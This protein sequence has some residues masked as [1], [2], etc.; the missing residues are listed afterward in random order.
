MRNIAPT[1]DQIEVLNKLIKWYKNETRNYIT[2]G[3]YAGTGKTTVV[4]LFR[5][6]LG[7]HEKKLKVAFCSYTGK[8]ALVLKNRLASLQARF[9]KDTVGTIHSLIY[10]PLVASN[11]EI[12]G[13]ELKDDIKYDLLVVDEASMLDSK[14]W[15]D[16]LSFGIRI[17]AVG[18]HGQLPPING[19]FNLMQDPELKLETIHRQASGDPIIGLSV[20]AR[21]K[22][23]IPAK[24]FGTKTK[25]LDSSLP[26]SHEIIMSLLQNWSEDTIVLCGYNS[27]RVKINNFVR[28]ALGIESPEPT[29]GDRVICLRNNHQKNIFNGMIG[30][31]TYIAEENETMYYAEIIFNE[32]PEQYSGH[33]LKSQF[34]NE[35]SINYTKNRKATLKCD[36]FDFGYAMTVHKAQGSEAERVILFEE[37]F[38]KLDDLGWRRWLY[39]AI[40]RAKEEL[41][42]LGPA[43]ELKNNNNEN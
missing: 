41:Y 2:L 3:G 43:Q 19:I 27:T 17:I 30:T 15:S 24:S 33:I 37:R 38:P 11:N 42:I 36:L 7:Q 23:H 40:T 35:E 22:G 26:E 31:I 25:K 10:T 20:L 4:S 32:L 5:V 28:T 21:K 12:I 34:N 39:T 16:L 14:I 13:W 29:V 18:D 8:G 9:P 6:L 1:K